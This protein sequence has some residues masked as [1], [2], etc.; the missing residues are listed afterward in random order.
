MQYEN[1]FEDVF[2]QYADSWELESVRTANM[3]SMFR[4]TYDIQLKDTGLSKNMIDS[5]R[6][7]NGNLEI[8]LSRRGEGENEL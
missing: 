6:C 8:S 5:L 7:R 1:V 4:L 3:G 2:R